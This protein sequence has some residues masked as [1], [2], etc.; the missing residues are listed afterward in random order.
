M[1]RSKYLTVSQL[2]KYLKL[3]FDR[4]PY[5]RT[6]YLTGELSNF[7]LRQRHQYFSL[8]DDHAVIDAVMFERP[9]PDLHRSDGTGRGWLAVRCL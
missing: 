9:L 2:T 5:L 8:K 3:K 7:R 6:V 4:D 1:D